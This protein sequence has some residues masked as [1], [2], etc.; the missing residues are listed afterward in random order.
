MTLLV[1]SHTVHYCKDGTIVGW[2]STVQ[3]INEL[4]C[5]FSKIIHVACL[6]RDKE[7]PLGYEPYTMGNV[8]FVPI[9]SAGGKGREKLT[10]LAVMPE[11][12][13]TVFRELRRATCFQ[14][15]APTAMG[16]YLIPM[17]T[18]FSR[19]PGW[20]K[21]GG[22]WTSQ[23][24]P[25]TY[26]VQRFMLRYFQSR[27]VT[28]NGVWPN[29]PK[30]CLSFE[31][32]CLTLNA[33]VQGGKA[34]EGKRYAPP[35]NIVFV[36]RLDANKGVELLV[37]ALGNLDDRSSLGEVHLVG[38]GPERDKLYALVKGYNLN[39]RF[40][41]FL[42]RE[43]VFELLKECHL[44][45]LPS[46]SEGF[47]KVLS[48]A[49]NFGCIPIVTRISAIDQY[50]EEGVSGFLLDGNERS[51]NG[52]ARKLLDVLARKDLRTI[53]GNGRQLVHKFTYK[54]YRERVL[55]EI[56]SGHL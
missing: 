22:A 18:V 40:H 21:Y 49:W 25:L 34:F 47:P 3:E 42:I 12:V 55:E 4:A 14:F 7:A 33:I 31:N 24:V 13:Q 16:L 30:H 11:I 35:Y 44:L 56:L 46:A 37:R 17:L 6:R 15:R 19:K 29:Q 39:V 43:A 10:N 32:P 48:E 52:I 53:A 50:L 1:I 28:I 2:A 51:V 41:G 54:H 26:A 38:D 9:P 27:K 45:V 23:S 5:A 8:E 36:G 20:F